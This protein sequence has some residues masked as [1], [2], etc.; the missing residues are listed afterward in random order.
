MATAAAARA[1]R[2]FTTCVRTYPGRVHID[3]KA[4]VGAFPAL[5]VRR[6]LRRLR[7]PSQ[8]RLTDLEG[9]AGLPPGDGRLLLKVL[10]AEGLIQAA[11][12]GAW[13]LS[14]AGETFSSASAARP[15]TRDTADRALAQFLDR[16]AR[17]NGDPY[18]LARANR[19]VLF[20]SLLR[21]EVERLSDVDL[22]VELVEKE[23]DSERAREAN[24]QRA[25]HLAAVGH[26]FRGILEVA[27][28]GRM[29]TFRFLKGGSRVI[30]LADYGVDRPFVL[31]V[32]HQFLLGE[33][34]VLQ[35]EPS[36]PKP[37]KAQARPSW[38][39]F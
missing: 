20:G 7:G 19:V 22:A 11:G 39:P 24:R 15:V 18:F 17:V 3:P 28:C 4:T 25:E 23:T 2:G 35:E 34:E 1:G 10:R 8:W 14:Q 26:R 38:S 21:P 5:V 36:P 31:A 13:E 32:P 6:A 12:R 29:E 30:A 16:V 9:A 27:S 37:P 33:P